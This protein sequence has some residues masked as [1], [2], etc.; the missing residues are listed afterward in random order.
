MRMATDS[1]RSA[2]LSIESA[3]LDEARDLGINLSR[4]SEAGIRSSVKAEKER[5]WLEENMEAIQEYNRWIAE[6]GMPFQGLRAWR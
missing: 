1:K 4:A 5:R 2:N 3:L 6:N